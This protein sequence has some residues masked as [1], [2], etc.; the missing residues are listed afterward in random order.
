MI[1]LFNVTAETKTGF[2][3]LSYR[4]L[5]DV[6][7][8]YFGTYTHLHE[9][10][11]L[12]SAKICNETSLAVTW[13]ISIRQYVWHKADI[14]CTLANAAF[15]LKTPASTLNDCLAR[16]DRCFSHYLYV[17]NKTLEQNLLAVLSHFVVYTFKLVRL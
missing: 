16:C 4:K 12:T 3:K 13:K 8:Y 2:Y 17:F 9:L 1:I 6:S 15:S 10:R 11:H 14:T 5:V 7:F